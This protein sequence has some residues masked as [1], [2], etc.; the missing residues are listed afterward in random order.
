MLVCDVWMEAVNASGTVIG[1]IRSDANGRYNLSLA[2]NTPVRIRLSAH[3]QRTQAGG[4]R[5]DVKVA[6]NTKGNA[7]CTLHETDCF[8]AA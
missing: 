7:L 3:M 6:D 2:A 4:P 8:D 1:C 5:W